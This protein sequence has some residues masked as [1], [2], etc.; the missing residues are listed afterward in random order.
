MVLEAVLGESVSFDA[1]ADVVAVDIAGL[2][3]TSGS[4][5]PGLSNDEL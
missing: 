5:S 3:E 4:D 2:R 1:V